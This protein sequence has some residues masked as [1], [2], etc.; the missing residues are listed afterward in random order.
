MLILIFLTCQASF[1][2]TQMAMNQ[3]AS[4][5]FEQADQELNAVYQQILKRYSADTTFLAALRASQRIWITFRDAE[6]KMKYPDRGANWYG[7]SHPMCVASYKA[8]LT[9]DRTETLQVWVKG[10]EE[11]EVC[12]GSVGSSE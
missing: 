2:Q 5:T 12:A 4:G 11:G 8:Q 9:R 1:A 7:S 6:L 10:I 3:E